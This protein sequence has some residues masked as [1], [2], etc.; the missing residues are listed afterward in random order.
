[1]KRDNIEFLIGFLD[2]LRRDDRDEVRS[3][4]KLRFEL[5]SVCVSSSSE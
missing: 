4:L 1:M 5:L 2:A 3:R